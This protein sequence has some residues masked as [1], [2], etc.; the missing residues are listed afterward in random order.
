M[1][2]EVYFDYACPYCYRSYK[3]LKQLRCKYPDLSVAF[4]P[5]EA[6]P[7]PDCYG[8]HSDLCIRGMYFAKEQGTD[9]WAYHDRVYQAIYE[10]GVIIDQVETF[11]QVMGGLLSIPELK[12]VL[13]SERYKM[14]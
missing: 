14:E 6:H 7:R 9:L 3:D 1:V 5:C 10:D 11:S 4:M 8:P 2:L 12:Q 13:Y